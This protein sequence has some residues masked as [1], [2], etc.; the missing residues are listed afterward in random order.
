MSKI[1]VKKGDLVEVIAGADRYNGKNEGEGKR[2]K[3]LATFPETNRVVVEGVA[4][5]TKHQKPTRM[6]ESG[7]IVQRESAIDASN[8]M[9]VCK[10]CGKAARTGIKVLE[11]GK[12][13]RYCK[14]CGEILDAE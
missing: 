10:S 8:V 4:M 14:R 6:G 3:V 1:H 2:G 11:D 9:L 5:V 7:G 13:V 12:K